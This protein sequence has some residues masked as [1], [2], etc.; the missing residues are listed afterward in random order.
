MRQ[1]RPVS[2]PDSPRSSMAAGTQDNSSRDDSM[3][4]SKPSVHFNIVPPVPRKRGAIKVL[5]APHDID[6]MASADQYEPAV[7][8]VSYHDRDMESFE[9]F[10]DEQRRSD[11]SN[12]RG[13]IRAIYPELPRMSLKPSPA[14][15]RHIHKS[16]NDLDDETSTDNDLMLSAPAINPRSYH[17]GL[18]RVVSSSGGNGGGSGSAN[19]SPS[20]IP[21]RKSSISI[22]SSMDHLSRR[23]S[24]SPHRKKSVD[25][26]GSMH[27][28][29]RTPSRSSS[30]IS[31]PTTLS[32][33]IGTPNKDCQQDDDTLTS[34]LSSPTKIPIRRNSNVN[35]ST[36]LSSRSNSR[37]GSRDPSPMKGL[38]GSSNRSSPSK[39]PQKP[40]AKLSPTK[41]DRTT[42]G[43]K[44]VSDE[45]TIGSNRGATKE[46][47]SVRKESAINRERSSVKKP[48]AAAIKREPSTLK[49][50]P[51][52]LKRET[53][54]LKRTPSNLKRENSTLANRKT[55]QSTL[56]KN[57]SD[58]SLSKR[59]DANSFKNRR[60]TSSESDGLNELA[61]AN[62]S[63]N[64]I[65]INASST[66]SMRTAAIASQPAQI[67]AAVTNQLNKSSS[68][69]QILV[70][71]SNDNNNLISNTNTNSTT[72]VSD[73]DSEK[74]SSTNLSTNN[75]ATISVNDGSNVS[76]TGATGATG[77][78]TTFTTT[79]DAQK[80]L[81]TGS[82]MVDDV[83][84]AMDKTAG[85]GGETATMTTTT[86]GQL[87]KKASS[88]TLGAK[89]D[90]GS[91]S[92]LS[93]TNDAGRMMLNVDGGEPHANTTS[94]IET[95]VNVIDMTGSG[96]HSNNTIGSDTET[97]LR[98]ANDIDDHRSERTGNSMGPDVAVEDM[99]S[100]NRQTNKL[101]QA[102]NDIGA[103]INPSTGVKTEM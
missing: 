63:D 88:R 95:N 79:T 57:Q 24:V 29:G 82:K 52:N 61:T 15:R 84:T 9:L 98:P 42:R 81:E 13:S 67:T 55:P 102:N 46:A 48:P 83:T 1:M 77:G 4:P 76:V 5:Q 16:L 43:K 72:N 50:Q 36:R 19:V 30:R 100:A 73:V 7:I 14:P 80:L 51:S 27:D 38:G 34:D 94:A 41:V 21:R 22:S 33:I 45:K 75:V 86:P 2:C 89:S 11:N 44:A 59:I 69:S 58:S 99:N 71:N 78:S 101:G 103:Y 49:R 40:N 64:L 25:M 20:K 92:G 54:T 70:N 18:L 74:K 62:T 32:P 60:R 31:K 3:V 35:L 8:D 90:I 10:S 28:L 6:S 23:Y 87:M 39:L 26:G 17:K 12:R 96:H 91:M 85:G 93:V 53:S 97:M 66:V 47:S 65:P 56:H 68:T 37:S